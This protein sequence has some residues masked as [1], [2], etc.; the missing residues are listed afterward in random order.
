MDIITSKQNNILKHCKKLKNKKYRREYNEFFIE[1]IRFIEEALKA[2]I[3]IKYFIVA[4]DIKGDRLN[5]IVRQIK[6]KNIDIFYIDEKLKGEIFE[7][8]TPQGIG[9][10]IEKN[11]YELDLIIPKANFI[12]IIDCIQD[13]GNLG[14]IIRTAHS[15]NADA[16]IMN[17]GT[18][19][20]YS[21]KVLRATMGSIFNIP[22]IQVEDMNLVI[23]NLKNNS[24]NVYGASPLGKNDYFK[25]NYLEKTAF[26]I[27]NEGNGIS[28]YIEN[29]CTSLIKIPMLGQTESLNAS[30]AAGILIYEAVRQ[31]LCVD[32]IN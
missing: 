15:A 12:I 13:P 17:E 10:I 19:D 14:T 20:L 3:S 22:I 11:N 8:D 32:K 1:G 28:E 24:F 26:V 29:N 31:R 18:V 4:S 5:N 16:I 9:A 27:G 7:T 6:D 25:N 30:V 21:S 2:K 23:D